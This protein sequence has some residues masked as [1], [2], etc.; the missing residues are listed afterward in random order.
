[1]SAAVNQFYD[2]NQEGLHFLNQ[3]SVVLIQKKPGA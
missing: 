1:M 3:V 2:R